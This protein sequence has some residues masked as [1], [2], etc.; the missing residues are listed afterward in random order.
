MTYSATL[1]VWKAIVKLLLYTEY[2]TFYSFHG[3]VEIIPK[4]NLITEEEE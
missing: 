1:W 3:Q 2:T 4:I